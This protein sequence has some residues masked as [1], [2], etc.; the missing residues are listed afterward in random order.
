[1]VTGIFLD[2]VELRGSITSH[3][4]LALLVSPRSGAGL[5][6]SST[7]SRVPRG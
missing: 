3:H 5:H 2:I 7:M 4:Q 6:A 1:M